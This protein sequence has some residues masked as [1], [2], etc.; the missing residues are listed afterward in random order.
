MKACRLTR[1]ILRFLRELFRDDRPASDHV[2]MITG[3]DG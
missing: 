2:P 1:R 3:L